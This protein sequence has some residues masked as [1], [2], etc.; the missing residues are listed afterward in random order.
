MFALYKFS[1]KIFLKGIIYSFIHINLF[2]G[3]FS[4]FF[5]YLFLLSSHDIMFHKQSVGI[6]KHFLYGDCIRVHF[7]LLDFSKPVMIELFQACMYS[8]LCMRIN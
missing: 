3:Y 5:F 6:C 7:I 8:L 2:Y 4:V 1:L